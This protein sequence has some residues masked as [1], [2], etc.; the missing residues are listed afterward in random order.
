MLKNQF[1]HA[2]KKSLYD[3]SW[4]SYLTK[5]R[6]YTLKIQTNAN[7]LV[8]FGYLPFC[9]CK[10]DLL[11]KTM[12]ILEMIKDF[13]AF[14]CYLNNVHLQERIFFE[15]ALA[16]KAFPKKETCFPKHFRLS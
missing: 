10:V 12:I 16:Q 7:H 2:L 9:Y 6:I 8:K 13:Q 14:L 11:I 15:I 5:L 4:L 1:A 3:Y